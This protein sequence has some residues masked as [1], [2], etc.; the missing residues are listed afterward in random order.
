MDWPGLLALAGKSMAGKTDPEEKPCC[1]GGAPVQLEPAVQVSRALPPAEGHWIAGTVQTPVGEIPRVTTELRWPDRLTAWRA[2]CGIR[3][4]HFT[5]PPGLYAVGDPDP[6]S[7]VLVSANYQLSFDRLRSQLAGRPAWI[8]VLDTRGINVWCAAGKGTF[9]TEELLRRLALV[10]LFRVVSHRTLIV[11]QLGATGVSAHQVKD[12]SGFKVVFGPVLAEDLPAF[13]D[14]GLRATPE[15][16]R[17]RFPL[18][19]RLVLVPVEVV[20][21]ARISL[22]VAGGLFVLS[23][24]GAGIFSVA[25]VLESGPASALLLLGA[26]LAGTA[27]VPALLPWLPG[28]AFAVKGA[29]VGW[30]FLL[31][32]GLLAGQSSGLLANWAVT[33]G[34]LLMAPAVTSYLGMNFTGASTFTSLSGVL[35]EMRMA[36]PVQIGC[37]ALG[38]GFWLTGRFI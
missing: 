28:R 24:L 4:L 3:R 33:V 22:L 38:L 16:R 13:L 25:R 31:A 18:R 29:V 9:G 19:D 23:G 17:V 1:C 37:A 35:K 14:A 15:M 11:P 32:V 26:V 36:V 8:L 30:L 10:G 7:P 21:A 6:E 34:W 12:R 2:R 5:V 20:G 27:L